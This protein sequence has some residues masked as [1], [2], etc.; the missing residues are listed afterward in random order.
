MADDEGFKV[1]GK[2]GRKKGTVDNKNSNSQ[3]N[4]TQPNKSG[5]TGQQT[6][7]PTVPQPLI[8]LFSPFFESLSSS[9]NMH[10]TLHPDSISNSII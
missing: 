8:S 7:S 9:N 10:Q 6:S 3:R 4:Q 5:R 2:R 1:Q